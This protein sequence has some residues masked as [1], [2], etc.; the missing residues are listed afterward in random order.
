MR[1]TATSGFL[2]AKIRSVAQRMPNMRNTIDLLSKTDSC[3]TELQQNEKANM[4]SVSENRVTN[5][6][7]SCSSSDTDNVH[8]VK[9]IDGSCKG[10]GTKNSKAGIGV[11]WGDNH[12]WNISNILSQ[13]QN[14]ALTNN[15]AELRAAIRALEI[16]CENKLD[17]LIINSDSKYVVLGIT[18]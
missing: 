6:I 14:D 11:C 10:N 16:T 9:Y 18:E 4:K 7:Q 2:M 17:Q 12:P 5:E 13:V 1:D 8:F 3:D 15:K